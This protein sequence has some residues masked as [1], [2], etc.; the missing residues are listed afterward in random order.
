MSTPT[1]PIVTAVEPNAESA[2]PVLSEPARIINTF[3]APSK[4]FLDIR[5]NA[6]WWVPW[7]LI[8]FFAIA[9]WV[10]VDKKVGFDQIA[11]NFVANSRQ[12]Q[13]QPPEQQARMAANV[14]TFTKYS[15]YAGP[16]FTLF[17]A[18]ITAV[19]LWGTF[20]FLTAAEISFGRSMA[21]V[22][23]GWLPGSLVS[24]VLSI[25]A[26][27]FGN[28]EGFRVESP[29]GTNPA[30]FMD[31]HTTSRFLLVA[32]SSLDVLGLWMVALVG[33]GFALNAKKKLKMGTA[34]GTVAAWYFLAKLVGAAFS[35]MGG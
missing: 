18:L 21:I 26:V 10:M 7:L 3:A 19:V 20:N 22:M 30:Y 11:Q 14:A 33:I 28:P 34:I 12:F 35:S 8:S 24:S 1:P 16:I 15:G 32:L 6:S 27:S 2:Q 13:A 5:R 4:T 23:Y 31:P 29:V 9:F 17:L 25:I